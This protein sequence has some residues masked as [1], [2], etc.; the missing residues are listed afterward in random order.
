[1][2]KKEAWEFVVQSLEIMKGQSER[3][4]EAT[5][6]LM[7]APESPLI[8]PFGVM[9][10][11]LLVALSAMVSDDFGT[12]HFWVYECKY[13]ERPMKAGVAGVMREIR[14]YED[15]KWLLEIDGSGK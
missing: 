12:L 3:V 10:E 6:Q 7:I 13:G 5:N 1:M 14:S 8:D 15:L 2:N 11:Q 9:C 4:G